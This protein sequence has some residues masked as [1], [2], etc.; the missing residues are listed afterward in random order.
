[1]AKLINNLY[2]YWKR[3][4][5]ILDPRTY[6]GQFEEIT[7]N[8]PVFLLGV[9]GGGLTLISRILRRH[10]A[11][12]SVTG[13][14]QYWA[15]A[16]EMHTVFG[17]ILPAELT[18]TRYKV[19]HAKHEIFP[20]PR[21]W[22]YACDELLPLYRKTANDC[23]AELKNKIQR[24]VRMILSKFSQNNIPSR[25]TDKSQ[26]FTVR[27]S[28]LNEIFKE[29]RPKFILILTN[30]YI[31]CYKAA[32][33]KAADM[34]KLKNKL[35]FH[36]R[37]EI[38]SQHWANSIQCALEDN[39]ENML[40]ILFEDILKNPIKHIKS[41][42]D[43]VELDFDE[44]MLPQ[45]HHKIPFGSRFSD[46]WYPLE[47]NRNNKYLKSIKQKELRIIDNEC[48]KIALQFGYEI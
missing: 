31:Q 35:S 7:I 23:T 11:V 36:K 10:P 21:S 37:L 3:N 12:V 30:P 47:P 9:Q 16:D 44:D 27:V 17:P 46:R 19:P 39:N 18:G 41:I 1:M 40:I 22:T 20:L 13:N 8:K 29:N 28:L 38:C 33:G 2:Y 5:W 4:N 32:N 34:K 26:V 14:S 45:Q 15:G 24:F 43:F 48:R 25:F 42:C 6:I